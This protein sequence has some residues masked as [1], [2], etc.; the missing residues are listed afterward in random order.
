VLNINAVEQLSLFDLKSRSQSKELGQFFTESKTA[1][2]MASMFHSIDNVELVNILDAGAGEGILT[3]S[4]A[5]RC[6]EIGNRR[7]HA[8]LFEIDKSRKNPM[9][10]ECWGLRYL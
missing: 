9:S 5:R 6:L 1:D 8:V 7:V 3:A 10:T 4:A 2:Y